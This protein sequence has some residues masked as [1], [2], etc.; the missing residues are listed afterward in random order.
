MQQPGIIEIP[1][2]TI[3]VLCGEVFIL[4]EAYQAPN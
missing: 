4:D 1:W 3:G 2:T